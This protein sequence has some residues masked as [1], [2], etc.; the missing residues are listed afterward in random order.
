MNIGTRVE[1][2]ISV[3]DAWARGAAEALNG[4]VGTITAIKTEHN[5]GVASYRVPTQFLVELDTAP[6]PWG[7]RGHQPSRSWWFLAGELKAI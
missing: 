3:P 5:A 4:L 6:A 1:V 2:A 7:G